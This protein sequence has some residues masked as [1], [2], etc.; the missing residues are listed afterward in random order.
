MEVNELTLTIK[1]SYIKNIFIFQ[2]AE[3]FVNHGVASY[4]HHQGHEAVKPGCVH[5]KRFRIE[6]AG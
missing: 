6:G 4:Y 1:F 5:E 2:A 3:Q